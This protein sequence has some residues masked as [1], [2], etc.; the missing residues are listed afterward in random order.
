V[1][2]APG[3]D[4]DGDALAECLGKSQAMRTEL[5]QARQSLFP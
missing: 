3:G 4:G 1:V 2:D 5:Q